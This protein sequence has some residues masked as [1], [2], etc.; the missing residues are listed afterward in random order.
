M[1]IDLSD[2]FDMPR[3]TS[4]GFR[5]TTRRWTIE[6][7]S[8]IEQCMGVIENSTEFQR[9]L[10]RRRTDVL[11][12]RRY[13]LAVRNKEAPAI[14][15]VPPVISVE[16]VQSEQGE[17]GGETCSSIDEGE[18]LCVYGWFNPDCV[19]EAVTG[20]S[21]DYATEQAGDEGRIR[22]KYAT[23]VEERPC[24]NP[25]IGPIVDVEYHGTTVCSGEGSLQDLMEEALQHL[26]EYFAEMGEDFNE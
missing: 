8:K 2:C 11:A 17:E 14:L 15:V 9:C 1:R 12:I 24:D 20:A 16:G 21:M 7:L 6:D 13:I 10:G 3:L 23:G 4:L 25:Q 22:V 19:A 18:P 26:D 5:I